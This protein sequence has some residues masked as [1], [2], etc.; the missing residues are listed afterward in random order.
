MPRPALPLEPAAGVNLKIHSF[1]TSVCENKRIN[2]HKR[3]IHTLLLER[4]RI[5]WLNQ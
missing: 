1:Y 5:D 2:E 3:F 4:E